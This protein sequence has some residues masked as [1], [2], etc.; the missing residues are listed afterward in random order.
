MGLQVATSSVRSI[1]LFVSCCTRNLWVLKFRQG[2][3]EHRIDLWDAELEAFKCF[4]N[5]LYRGDYDDYNKREDT[6]LVLN[7]KVY[8]MAYKYDVP[9]LKVP[10]AAKYELCVALD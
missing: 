10:A 6:C 2:A 5:F 9:P 3:I 4:L 8:M 7:T 1:Y